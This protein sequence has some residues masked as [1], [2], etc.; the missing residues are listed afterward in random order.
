MVRKKEWSSFEKDIIE[1]G[2]KFYIYGAGFLYKK[3]IFFVKKSVVSIIDKNAENIEAITNNPIILPKELAKKK[4]DILSCLNPFDN[5]YKNK[6][7]E[8]K[9]YLEGIEGDF[10]L[11]Y[12]PDE[13]IRNTGIIRWNDTELLLD[14]LTVLV[15]G[16][17]RKFIK[18]AYDGIE[19]FGAGYLSKLYEEPSSYEYYL[20]IDNIGLENFDN[21]LIVH[22]KGKKSISNY[23]LSAKNRIWLF[24][25][26][27]VSGMLN[28][29]STTIAY[30]LQNLVRKKGFSVINAG[31]PGR[32][33]ER[34]IYQIDNEKI[35]EKDYVFL[36][37]GF[38]E[39]DDI[40]NN[41]IVWAK[42]IEKAKKIVD[43]KCALFA[44][45]N[46][47]T[48]LEMKKI[49]S[50]EKDIL[51]LF[52]TTEFLDYK[53]D[54]ISYSNYLIESYCQNKGIRYYN[55]EK[56]FNKKRKQ[57]GQVFINL[58]HYGPIGNK[59]IA[60]ELD[61]IIKLDFFMNDLETKNDNSYAQRFESITN[62]I[63]IMKNEAI[64]LDDYIQDIKEKSIGFVLDNEKIGGVVINANPF[65]RGHAF[66]IENA[67]K[68]VDKLF[69]F[70]VSEDA[71]F[72]SFKDRFNIVKRN[73]M[74][75]HRVRVVPSGKFCISKYTFP[76]YFRKE[77]IQNKV[78]STYKDIQIF[79]KKIAPSL[80]IQYRFVGEEPNDYITRQYNEEMRNELFKY[81]ISF[82]EIPRAVL[83]NGEIISATV[84]R[85]LYREN[86]WIEMENFC[87]QETI[88]F[89]KKMKY[90]T[91]F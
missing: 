8:I 5:K 53:K 7:D 65:T 33:I 47:P 49:T 59:L 13:Y 64:E 57:Y 88:H 3:I 85:K 2:K 48:V 12:L 74:H 60:K 69:V 73:T 78:I 43:S 24:G 58:H 90:S 14:N 55:F 34:M 16:Y 30:Y 10:T 9:Y 1:K 22:E 23:N 41:A 21:G 31:I 38:Y 46:L 44:Y 79:A 37:T 54:K 70:V 84:V 89:L 83:K 87:T 82:I 52:N 56:A 62:R 77:E 45:I 15:N 68:I 72:F 18:K 25:D 71:S 50:D 26:S 80:N 76:D 4:I 63:N 67:L 29:N 39:F 28:A 91:I 35:K 32:D 19:E 81:G 40:D 11:Y 51:L 75:N 6:T 36:M 86:K 66:L 20:D 27:R 61:E 17:D 42:F